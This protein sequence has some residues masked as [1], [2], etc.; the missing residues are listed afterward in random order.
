MMFRR[1][2]DDSLFTSSN[3]ICV[4]WCSSEML[5]L[6]KTCKYLQTCVWHRDYFQWYSKNPPGF[7]SRGTRAVLPFGLAY[8]NTSPLHHSIFGIDPCLTI[9]PDMNAENHWIVFYSHLTVNHISSLGYP[10]RCEVRCLCAIWPNKLIFCG[11][12]I[13]GGL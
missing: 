10:H 8:K 4:S 7:L 5:L 9:N 2:D 11:S 3:T 6:N 1:C 12:L 13:N